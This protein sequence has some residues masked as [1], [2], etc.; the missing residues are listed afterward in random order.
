VCAFFALGVGGYFLFNNNT[1]QVMVG[2][3]KFQV[4]NSV[5]NASSYSITVADSTDTA[6]TGQAQYVVEKQ[7]TEFENVN[8]FVVTV[9]KDGTKIAEEKYSQEI[10][11]INEETNKIDCKIQNYTII[12]FDSEG[13]V[14]DERSSYVD[15][16]LTNVDSDI[17]CCVVNTYFDNLFKKDGVYQVS[18]TPLDE[19]GNVLTGE[20]GESLVE[21]Q[22]YDYT[23]YYEEDFLKRDDF[24][25]DGVWYDYVIE[26]EDELDALVWWA[27][28]YRQ[29]K[30]TT[31]DGVTVVGS[32]SFYVKTSDINS[33]N[34]NGKVIDAINSYPEYDALESQNVYAK[35]S[36]SLGFLT[37]FNYYLNEDFTLTYKDLEAMDTTADKMFYTASLAELCEKDDS[38]DTAY[39]TKIDDTNGNRTFALIAD[40]DDSGV[41]VYNTEQLFMVV[42]SGETPEFEEGD[43]VV[44]T[45]WNNALEVLGEINDSDNLTDY[46]KALNIYNY[47]CGDIVYDY[48]IY[49]YMDLKDDYSIN[50][51]GNF[52]CFYLEG[53]FYD[54]E[55]LSTHYAVCDGLAKAYSLLCNIEGID[56]VKVNG[57]VEGGNHAWDRI[58]LGAEEDYNLDAGY[59][60]VDN[61]WGEGVYK[62]GGVDYQVLTHSYFLFN[63]LTGRTVSYPKN[64]ERDNPSS[65]FNYYAN[66]TFE[67]NGETIDCEIGSDD[68][69]TKILSYAQQVANDKGS[70]VVEI[71]FTDDYYRSLSTT[72]LRELLNCR[73]SSSM[74]SWFEENGVTGDW[75]WLNLESSSGV[76]IFKIFK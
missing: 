3:K 24:Y 6:N 47:I 12:F 75:E 25:Y 72:S 16:T 73:D 35:M 39:V 58:Y 23:A 34:I 18:L 4:F 44:K 54:F 74:A 9:S 53:V 41:M 46:E 66:T 51:F 14:T 11:N 13:N 50:N 37:N 45:V 62:D 1:E 48:V 33:G 49:E 29:A 69:F 20:N 42:Q 57:S 52:S 38:Y 56:C 10:T 60:Y 64:L 27:V 7:G 61:T 15:Q 26:N 21:V 28:L 65:D 70:Y 5:S 55:G 59:Y 32:L 71:D 36:N 22:E 67:Y 31:T 17:F 19:N 63:D 8:N 40:N 43:S 68:E 76:M 30:T 2:S